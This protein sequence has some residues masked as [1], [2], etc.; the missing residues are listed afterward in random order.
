MARPR[1]PFS[2]V[3]DIIPLTTKWMQEDGAPVLGARQR[4]RWEASEHW[5]YSTPNGCYD[6][7]T[8]LFILDSTMNIDP[9]IELR[10]AK[11]VEYLQ[12]RPYRMSWDSTTVGKVLSDLC[13]AFEDVLGAKM[14]L[15]ER[16]RDYKG[17]FY[18]IHRNPATAKVAQGIREDLYRLTGIEIEARSN[19]NKPLALASPLLE[20][21]NARGAWE[22]I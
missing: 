5:V 3:E 19:G 17:T 9:D 18:R 16:G 6:P 7:M 21:P 12:T 22:G 10:A 15:L 11:L 1:R 8:Y 20:C 2:G 14:G 13:D 4:A